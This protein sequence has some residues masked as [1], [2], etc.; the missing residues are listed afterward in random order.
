MSGLGRVVVGY[1]PGDRRVHKLHDEHGL[2]VRQVRKCVAGCGYPVFFYSGG[3][4]AAWERDAEV[5]CDNCYQE[6]RMDVQAAL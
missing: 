3:Y 6:N 4:D 5:M 1:R 2:E